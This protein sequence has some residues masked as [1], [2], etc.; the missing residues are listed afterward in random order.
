M[1]GDHVLAAYCAFIGLLLLGIL[2]WIRRA[3]KHFDRLDAQHR[4]DMLEAHRRYEAYQA[5]FVRKPPPE[6]EL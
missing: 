3:Q 1:S 4:V 6:E 2:W 5:T